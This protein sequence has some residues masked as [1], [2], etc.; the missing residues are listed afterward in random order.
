[1]RERERED[2]HWRRSNN[3]LLAMIIEHG[4]A[5][6]LLKSTENRAGG[7]TCRINFY[8]V[9]NRP[10]SLSLPLLSRLLHLHRFLF[11][12]RPV[13]LGRL[14]VFPV[15]LATVV[16]VFRCRH[17]EMPLR[18]ATL[19][20]ISETR[21]FSIKR[22]DV[23]DDGGGGDN[24]SAKMPDTLTDPNF[25]IVLQ[26]LFFNVRIIFFL[27]SSKILYTYFILKLEQHA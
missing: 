15:R 26:R 6:T 1:M 25:L 14:R 9:P 3:G 24:V 2:R 22:H 7:F 27:Y 8:L 19:S 23:D 12:A 17:W 16:V 21:D 4:A 11:F 5:G 10:L 18:R 13:F 20:V